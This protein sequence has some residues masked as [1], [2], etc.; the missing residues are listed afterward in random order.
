MKNLTKRVVSLFLT[1]AML[2][3]LVCVY[4]F[5]LSASDM[6]DYSEEHWAAEAL[7][8][9][10]EYDLIKGYEDG[11]IRPDANLTRAEMATVINRAF[12]ATSMTGSMKKQLRLLTWVP[13][14]VM[15]TKSSFPMTLSVVKRHSWLSREL[16]FLQAVR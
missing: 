11:T 5:A 15:N 16:L 8:W 10:V 9:A 3:P 14:K 13:S 2:M 6:A 4:P 1:L 12:G 7:E